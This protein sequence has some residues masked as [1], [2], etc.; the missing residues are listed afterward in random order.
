[1]SKRAGLLNE[2]IKILS[3][4]STVN[5]FGEKI[6]SYSVT[7]TTRARVDHNSGTRSNE[8]NEIFYSYQK[9]FTVRSYVPVTEFDLVEYNTK[10]YR[11]ITIEDRIKEYND[12]LIL[13]EL[14]ND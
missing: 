5:E 1:M 3:P 8:N 10:K 12:K 11:I 7:Y 2:V 13:T 14:I 9:T 6:Q 4:T